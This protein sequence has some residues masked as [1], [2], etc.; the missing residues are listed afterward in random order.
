[1]FKFLNILIFMK[2]VICDFL[3]VRGCLR[4]WARI[5]GLGLGWLKRIRNVFQFYSSERKSINLLYLNII[6]GFI[7]LNLFQESYLKLFLGSTNLLPLWR[8][9]DKLNFQILFKST[10]GSQSLLLVGLSP[11]GKQKNLLI[12]RAT[13]FVITIGKKIYSNSH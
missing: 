12:I 6:R 2:Y 9:L 3:C 11:L 7:N 4:V 5:Y 8:N 1:M 10:V 13:L